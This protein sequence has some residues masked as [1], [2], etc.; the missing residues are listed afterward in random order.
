MT[1]KTPGVYIQEISLF[2]PS[3]AQVETAIPA[4]VGYTEKASDPNEKSLTNTPVRI[5]SLVEF[6]SLFGGEYVPASYA[7]VADATKNNALVAVTPDKRYYLFDA[8]RQFYDNGGGYCYIVSV[9]SY[10][11]PIAFAD[12]KKGFDLLRKVD[13]P[14]LLLAPDAVGL[15]DGDDEPDLDKFTDLQKLLLTQ[16]CALGEQNCRTASP[17]SIFSAAPFRKT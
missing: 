13:E 6:Q 12:L 7:V 15:L 5:K 2:P 14:T 9:N 1:Y 17:S 8:L 10:T 16:F 3:V 4:F 11:D